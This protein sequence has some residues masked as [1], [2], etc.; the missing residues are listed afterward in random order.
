[1]ALP[2]NILKS[3]CS[4]M[5]FQQY[6]NLEKKLF[7]VNFFQYLRIGREIKKIKFLRHVSP[8]LSTLKCFLGG[9][10]HVF[11]FISSLATWVT[12]IMICSK[13]T[14]FIILLDVFFNQ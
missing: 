3:R 8:D 1:V 2:Q 7:R 4:E 6:L 9:Y 13:L 11:W 10:E 5:R 12:V 14:C